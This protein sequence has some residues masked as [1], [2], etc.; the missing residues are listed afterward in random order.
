MV[1]GRSLC[2]TFTFQSKPLEMAAL[3][4]LEEPMKAVSN[5]L[6][7]LKMYDLAW[8]RVLLES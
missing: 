6:L 7:L 3:E 5:P 2:V 4:R 1:S 8:R